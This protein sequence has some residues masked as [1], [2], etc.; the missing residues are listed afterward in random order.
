MTGYEAAD[1]VKHL[2]DLRYANDLVVQGF[3]RAPGS[4]CVGNFKAGYVNLVPN[5]AEVKLTEN[6]NYRAW[7]TSGD[8]QR[9]RDVTDMSDEE[10][11]RSCGLSPP[12]FGRWTSTSSSPQWCSSATTTLPAEF[13]TA[14]ASAT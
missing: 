7:Y 5:P 3:L 8:G 6:P 12:I 9:R 2:V 14:A 13:T 10:F 11:E 4:Q 1:R